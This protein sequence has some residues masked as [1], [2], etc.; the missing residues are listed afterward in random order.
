MAYHP[1]TF[2]PPD[3]VL[4]PM[5]VPRKRGLFAHL[6][7]AMAEVRQRDADRKIASY[8][9]DHGGTF[10]DETERE[11]ECRFLSDPSRW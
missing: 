6:L 2:T 9:A 8:L 10:T 3:I 4:M 5:S 11:I 7:A 1:I